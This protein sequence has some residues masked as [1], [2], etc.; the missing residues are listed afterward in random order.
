MAIR[1]L[2]ADDHAVVRKG[3]GMLL[4]AEPDIEV[5]GEVEDGQAALDAVPKLAP[6]VILMDISMGRLNGLEATRRLKE[7]SKEAGPAVLILTIHESEEYFFQALEAGALGYVPKS[8]SH[9]DLIDAVRTVAGGQ[10]YLH[11]TVAR[12]L[13]NDYVSRGRLDSDLERLSPR[14]R[15]VLEGVA[16]GKTNEEIAQALELSVH[17]VRNHRARLMKKLGVHDRLE[18]LRFAIR[19][20]VISDS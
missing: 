10:A 18:L 6:D 19:Q 20:G 17:T 13:V 1:V 5:V 12:L 2:L 16:E 8:A 9:Y 7:T 3:L 15:Q 11:P 14:E 4:A